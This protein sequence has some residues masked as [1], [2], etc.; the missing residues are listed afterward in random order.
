MDTGQADVTLKGLIVMNQVTQCRAIK[1]N[2]ACTV[3]LPVLPLTGTAQHQFPLWFKSSLCIQI[4]HSDSYY[5]L[6]GAAIGL[7]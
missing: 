6:L 7:S 1:E 3:G 5:W 4:H 2:T